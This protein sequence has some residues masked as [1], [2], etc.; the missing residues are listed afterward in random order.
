MKKSRILSSPADGATPN[1]KPKNHMKK[2]F[3]ILHDMHTIWIGNAYDTQHAVEKFF[4][5]FDQTAGSSEIFAVQLLK[6][7]NT[8]K[9]VYSG[10]FSI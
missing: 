6:N 4:D 1:A 7:D 9:T 3:R 10:K 8:W 5:A 2:K